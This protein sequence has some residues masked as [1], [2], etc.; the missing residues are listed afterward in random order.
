MSMHWYLNSFIRAVQG[1]LFFRSETYLDMRKPRELYKDY[2]YNKKLQNTNESVKQILNGLRCVWQIYSTTYFKRH[3]TH[4][5]FQPGLLCHSDVYSELGGLQEDHL[6]D[7]A[8]CNSD[9]DWYDLQHW[10]HIGIVPWVQL[11]QR[12]WGYLL[13]CQIGHAKAK[14]IKDEENELDQEIVTLSRIVIISW[15]GSCMFGAFIQPIYI[16]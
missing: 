9:H 6:E 4:E 11:P 3:G 8:D 14:A 10:R 1:T 5:S 12:G 13:D 7:G 15:C 2:F 16:V